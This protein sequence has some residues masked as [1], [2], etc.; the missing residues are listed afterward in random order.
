MFRGSSWIRRAGVA[1]LLLAN[2]AAGSL[3]LPHTAGADDAACSP[4]AFAHDESAHYIGPASTTEPAHADHCFLCH[5]LRSFHPPFEKFDQPYSG[6]RTD[7]L[8]ATPIDRARVTAWTRV[9]G[10]APPV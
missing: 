9:S 4:V 10:R 2:L 7:R 1:L 5:S 8:Y 3:A 6:H